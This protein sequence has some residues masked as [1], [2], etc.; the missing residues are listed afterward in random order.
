[1]ADA[2]SRIEAWREDDN[3]VR[4]H[5]SLGDTPPSVFA[6]QIQGVAPALCSEDR[7][8]EH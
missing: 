6:V 7:E 2:S 8:E 5:S 3:E 4:P 1:L